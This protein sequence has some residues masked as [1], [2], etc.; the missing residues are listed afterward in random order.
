MFEA[1]I[2]RLSTMCKI[3]YV[4]WCIVS[5]LFIY[6]YGFHLLFEPWIT[7]QPEK[8]SNKVMTQFAEGEPLLR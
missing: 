2:F 5:S 4:T 6:L 8:L 7:E 3:L 1:P